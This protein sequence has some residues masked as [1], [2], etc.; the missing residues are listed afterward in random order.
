MKILITS[1]PATGLF[2]P[3]LAIGRILI[4]AGHEVAV[5]T[6]SA[7]RQRIEALERSSI[8]CLRR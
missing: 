1:T 5:L 3:L 6:G 7:F 8:H 4:A 2:N